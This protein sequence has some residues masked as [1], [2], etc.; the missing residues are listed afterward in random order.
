[1]KVLKV[2]D[3]IEKGQQEVED[4]HSKDDPEEN[5]IMD[6]LLKKMEV[7]DLIEKADKDASKTKFG[8]IKL[9][10]DEYGDYDSVAINQGNDLLE[11]LVHG[12]V[13]LNFQK[14][15]H[16]VLTPNNLLGTSQVDVGYRDPKDPLNEFQKVY[17]VLDPVALETSQKNYALSKL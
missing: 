11:E 12:K 17:V 1:M 8:E 6:G 7:I 15:N 5:N 13:P 9:T 16:Y 14:R 2:K 4:N 3:D 10:R